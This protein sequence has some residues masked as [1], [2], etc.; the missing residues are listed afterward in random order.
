MKRAVLSFISLIFLCGFIF[1]QNLT[2]REIMRE[3]SI[4]G[5][6]AESERLSPDGKLVAY[7]WNAEGKMPRDLYLVSTA[8]GTPQKILSPAEILSP[9]PT[10]TPDNKFDYGL[11][12]KDDFAKAR[13][14]GLNILDWSPD[15]KKLLLGQNGDLFILHTAKKEQPRRL[16]KTQAAEGA[17]RFLDQNRILFSQSGNL[18]VVDIENFSLVQVSKEANPQAFV[19]VFNA[20]PSENGAMVAYVVSDGSKQRALFVP[21]YLDQFTTAPTFRRGWTEQKVLAAKTDGSL[22]NPVEIKL[23]KAEGVSYIRGLDWAADNASLI[24]D[25]IDKDTKRRQLFYVYNVGGKGE[26]TILITEETDSKWVAPLSRIVEPNPKD[27]SQILF[28]SERDGYNHLYLGTLE[29]GKAEPNSK[30]EIRGENPASTGFTGKVDVKQ[31]TQGDWQ[32]EW[33]KWEEQGNYIIYLSTKENPRER[34]FSSVLANDEGRTQWSFNPLRLPN[35]KLNQGMITSPQLEGFKLLYSYS[36]WNKPEELF[37]TANNLYD[38]GLKLDTEGLVIQITKKTPENFLRRKWNEPKFIDIPSKDNKKIPAKIYLPANFNKKQKYPMVIFVHGAG[39][40][41]NVVNGWN[42]YY[43]EFMFNQLLTQKGYVVLDIDYRGSAG[44]GRDWRT[45]VHD[46]LGGLDYEDHIDS[47]DFMV[48]N[49]S[50]NPQKVGV[51]G[52]SY[53]GF[54]AGMLVMRAPDK[55]AAA[56]ALRPVFDWKNYFYSSP[57]YSTERL[58]FPDKN[59]E[60]YKRSSPIAYADKLQKPLLILHGLVDDN[61]HAQDSIQLIEKLM[62]LEKTQYFEAMLYPSENHAFQRPTSWA[63]EY[64]RI[65]TFFEKHLK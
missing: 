62:R 18:F 29:K 27:A 10:P 39:Y 2:V 36:E 37:V 26:Q 40:L 32:V 15:S 46:F 48:A 33:A 12:I 13:E 11:V 31:L 44:Y 50:V 41:Q 38:S 3:P 61:V 53:G 35:P 16:T 21:N 19:S 59:A 28:A 51:Y 24:V 17:A 60:A 63:D 64:E 43:R 65:L 58:G 20:T 5:M 22:A 56:A 9:V 23:P 6:R 52:G 1:G 14:N 7:L 30:G 34:Q 54:M 45:D 49:Y 25:R 47:I 8:G 55:I 4:A 42:N 57:I